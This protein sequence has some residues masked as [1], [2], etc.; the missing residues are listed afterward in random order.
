M[1]ET[2]THIITRKPIGTFLFVDDELQEHNLLK[3]A[4][5]ALGLDNKI[6]NCLTAQEAIDYMKETKD[7]IFAIFADLNMPK[8]DGLEFKRIVEITPDLKKRS[9]PFFFHSN[10]GSPAEIRTAY[11]LNIQGYLKKADSL[12]GTIA[13]L[14]KVIELWTEVVHPNELE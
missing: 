11:T 7:E 13:S 3:I 14:K 8:V 5:L 10:T 2:D 12:Q 4:V 9:I 1:Q 6:V